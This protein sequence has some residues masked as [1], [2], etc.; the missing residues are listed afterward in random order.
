MADAQVIRVSPGGTVNEHGR[1]PVY[2]LPAGPRALQSVL[3][4]G[5]VGDDTSDRPEGDPEPPPVLDIG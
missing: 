2:G 3:R 4:G 1:E 5:R